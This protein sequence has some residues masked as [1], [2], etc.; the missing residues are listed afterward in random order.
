M[1][2]RLLDKLKVTRRVIVSARSR[3]RSDT[4]AYRRKKL[5]ASLQEQIEL[6]EMALEGKPLILTRKRGHEE[7]SV[8]P[9][10]WWHQDDDGHVGTVVRY[11]NVNLNLGRRG[12]TIEVGPLR[13][14]PGIY[15]TVI[16]AV[17]AGELDRTIAAAR[18]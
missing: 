4:L 14:L 12:T 1:K 17:E 15:R 7:V 11:N 2:N 8:R 9:R 6:A 10:L 18:R 3:Q 16:N 5:I 13:K